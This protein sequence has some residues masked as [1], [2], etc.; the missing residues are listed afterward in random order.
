MVDHLSSSDDIATCKRRRSVGLVLAFAFL[1]ATGFF[2]VFSQ[3]RLARLSGEL[4]AVRS[5]LDGTRKQLAE[6]LRPNEARYEA[7]LKVEASQR[8]Q[9][10]TQ[11]TAEQGA[12]TGLSADLARVTSEMNR[13]LSKLEEKIHESADLTIYLHPIDMTDSKYLSTVSP[14]LGELLDK[15]L[16]LRSKSVSF[17]AA[18]A[19][20]VGFT[21]SGFAGYILQQVKDIPSADYPESLLK[22]LAAGS[23]PQLGDIIQY[24][25]GLS[26]FYLRDRKGSSFVIGMTPAGIAALNPNFD[27]KQ[28]GV[29]RTGLYK[30]PSIQGLR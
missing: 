19:P 12:I 17:D 3:E 30:W 11:L 10:S 24:E 28:T 25:T 20:S 2:V 14:L 26:M 6:T 18:N 29:L 9:E 16:I 21:S 27:A 7:N 13:K 23:T 22:T 5:D 4:V 8:E 15:I 1:A